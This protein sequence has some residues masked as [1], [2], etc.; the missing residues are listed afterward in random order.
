MIE[1][2]RLLKKTKSQ[3]F[4]CVH[5]SQTSRKLRPHVQFCLQIKLKALNLNCLISQ[6]ELVKW[7]LT[8]TSGSVVFLGGILLFQKVNIT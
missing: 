4:T 8:F 2:Y 5:I 6:T 1:H 7:A 3:V